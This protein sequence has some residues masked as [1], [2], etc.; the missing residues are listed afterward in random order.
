MA[1]NENPPALARLIFLV[2]S[3]TSHPVKNPHNIACKKEALTNIYF[4]LPHFILMQFY[5]IKKS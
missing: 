5:Y 3:Q 4:D 2:A 1:N